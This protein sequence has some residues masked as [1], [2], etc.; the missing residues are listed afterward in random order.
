MKKWQAIRQMHP[1]SVSAYHSGQLDKSFNSREKEILTALKEIKSGTY[2]EMA[3]HLGYGHKSAVQPRI[4]DLINDAGILEEMEISQIDS[5][6][7]KTVRMVRI[8][9]YTNEKQLQIFTC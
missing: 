2:R 7:G 5:I 8:V 6:T 4:S 1:N 9:P 3:E